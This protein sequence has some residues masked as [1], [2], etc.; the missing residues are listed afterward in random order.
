MARNGV[1][2]PESARDSELGAIGLHLCAFV[3]LEEARQQLKEIGATSLVADQCSDT[4]HRPLETSIEYPR[5][6][7]FFRLRKEGSVF[8]SV[9]NMP[10]GGLPYPVTISSNIVHDSEVS[11]KVIPVSGMAERKGKIEQYNLEKEP[12]LVLRKKREI[13]GWDDKKGAPHRIVLERVLGSRPVELVTIARYAYPE[14]DDLSHN[15]SDV[16]ISAMKLE[17]FIDYSYY[18]HT[19][20]EKVRP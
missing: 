1:K 7:C 9:H 15:W 19:Q 11:D 18:A 6:H 2:P 3:E 20:T 4:Y 10:I 17:R 12:H 14:R 5:K 13:Y 8:V 16:F